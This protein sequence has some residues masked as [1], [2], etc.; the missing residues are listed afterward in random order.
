MIADKLARSIGQTVSDDDQLCSRIDAARFMQNAD[1]RRS[2]ITG[3][4]IE[5]SYSY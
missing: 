4:T 2:F 1:N 3:I 5:A